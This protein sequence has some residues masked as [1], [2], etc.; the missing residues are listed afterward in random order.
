[1]GSEAGCLDG[2]AVGCVLGCSVGCCVGCVLG[3]V[4]GCMLGCVL[5]CSVGC[6]VGCVLGCVVGWPWAAA[7]LMRRNTATTRRRRLD[8]IEG[9]PLRL[10][11]TPGPIVQR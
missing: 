7:H 9:G 8:T 1:V 11:C 6:C 5:G 2:R 4:V 3:C 10:Q